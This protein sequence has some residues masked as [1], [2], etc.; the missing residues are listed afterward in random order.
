MFIHLNLVIFVVSLEEAEALK[1]ETSIGEEDGIEEVNMNLRGGKALPEPIKPRLP[2]AE[3]AK[4][5]QRTEGPKQ[6]LQQAPSSN[7]QPKDEE[8]EYNVIA[9]LK[10]IPA[11]L[12]VYDALML[13]PELREALIKALHSPQLYET[14]MAK[15]RLLTSFSEVNEI[16]FSEEDKMV[17]RNNHN[18]PLY[19]EG[20]IG[21]AHLRRILIDPG[22][23]VNLLPIRSLTRAGY[24]MDDLEP[25]N[26]VICGYDSNGS[27]ALGSITLKLQMSTFI[28]KVKF[29]VIEFVTSYSALLGRPWLHKYQ[30]IPSTLH[31]CFKFI[32]GK[33]EQQRVIGNL[34]PYTMQE[35]HH[36]DAKYFFPNTG[37]ESRL[38]RSNPPMDALVTPSLTTP[39]DE[40]DFLI[41][42][43]SSYS[44]RKGSFPRLRGGRNRGRPRA[45]ASLPRQ[46]AKVNN[47]EALWSW[48][49]TPPAPTKPST[50]ANDKPNTPSVTSKRLEIE[51]LRKVP[52]TKIV[53]VTHTSPFNADANTNQLFTVMHEGHPDPLITTASQV[54]QSINKEADSMRPVLGEGKVKKMVA[55]IEKV[56]STSPFFQPTSLYTSVAVPLEVWAIPDPQGC[57]C[58]T[59]FYKVPRTHPCDVSLNF[60][61]AETDEDEVMLTLKVEPSMVPLLEKAGIKLRRNQRLPAPPSICEEWWDQIEHFVQQGHQSHPRYGLGYHVLNLCDS[62]EE[63]EQE[64]EHVSCN[65]THVG[66]G[67][68]FGNDED[69]MSD[70]EEGLVCIY[71][72]PHQPRSVRAV[73]NAREGLRNDQ[74]LLS[75]VHEAMTVHHGEVL[76]AAPAPPQLE[77]GGQQTF[78]ELVEINLGSEDDPRPTFVS[79]SL[80]L[81]EREDYRNFL[82][83]YKDCFAWSYKEMPGLDPNVAT[84]K[85]GIDPQYRPVKQHPRRFRPELQD[86]IIAEVE[87]LIKSGFIK[88]V[89]YPRWLANIVPVMKK[90]GQVRVCVDFRDLNRTCPKDDFPIPNT[91]LVVDATTGYEILSFMDGFSG[92]NQIKMDEHDAIDTAFRTPKGNF[93]YTVMPFGLKNA[94]ATYQRAMTLIFGDLIHQSIEVYIDDLVVKSRDRRHHQEDLRVVFKRLRKYQLKMNPLKCAFAVQS[95]VFLGF[96]VRHRGIEI[97][98]KDITSILKMP[99]PEDLKELKSLQGKLAYIRRF[100]SNLSGRIQPFSRLMKKGAPFIWDEECQKAFDSIKQYLLHPPVLMAPIKGRPLILYIAAQ[101]NSVG[102]MLGQINDDGKE[103]ACYYL[104][105]TMVGAECNY[106][107]IEKLCLALIFALKKLRHYLLAH[108]VQLIAR[109][110]PVKYVLSQPALIGRIGK[111]ALLMMEY[112]I[113]YV[114]QKAVKGQAL[115]DFLAAHPVPDDSPLVT[116]LPDEE[117]FAVD[118]QDPWELY[119]DGASRSEPDADGTPRRRAGAGIVFK[120]PHGETI[121]HSFSLLK[122]E[123]SNNEAEYES[124]IFGL[125]L[126]LSM[127]IQHLHAY[128]DSQLIVRQ[129]NRIYE[130]RKPELV[131]YWEA[132]HKLMEKFEHIQVNH[133]PRSKNASADALAKLASS[134]SLPDGEAEI[135]VEER[136]LLPAVLELIP[137]SHEVNIVLSTETGDEDWRK[138]FLDYFK[139]GSLPSDSVERRQLQ[140]RLPSYIY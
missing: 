4:A 68:G 57:H 122:E 74:Y 124:L 134:L 43:C 54:D 101:P 80:T 3:K 100:I 42:P 85:L 120:S 82:M 2:S 99:P 83:E 36:A 18:R 117:V 133:V 111:W 52:P 12:S 5:V 98:P 125:L 86:D 44:G 135:R 106:S 35:V 51:S 110:D 112:D 132:A 20:N 128:G 34:S 115:A 27:Q 129:V 26:V 108:E 93:Y 50:S 38:G 140:R 105:R 8:V 127:N 13:M 19:I 96:V 119:F 72:I 53:D 126:A 66:D 113:T 69:L 17:E 103:V 75:R 114:P 24:T 91:E 95:G 6:D 31:Q 92:Y 139:H 76:N 33:G 131:A 46:E 39:A 7:K 55:E 67:W 130:V 21:S 25:T 9:H 137:E 40:M 94:G 23:A 121:Y 32:D 49:V 15:H 1:V 10:R 64:P 102:A 70:D 45:Y 123:C 41:Q 90:N 48:N 30:V 59:L 84:H 47:S 109:A 56:T 81:E 118:T 78:D 71:E 136:W 104:S 73:A 88:E 14:A 138:P 60:S 63:E 77:D 37:E 89:Q 16:S 79:A 62:D 29:F 97:K 58:P 107:P 61:D 11:L 65:M 87:K 28:F 116:D 22:S